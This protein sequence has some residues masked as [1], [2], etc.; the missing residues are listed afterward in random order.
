MEKRL[1][2][3][4]KS[5]EVRQM[6]HTSRLAIGGCDLSQLA[7]EYGTP[8]YIY[9]QLALDGAVDEA[10]VEMKAVG[11]AALSGAAYVANEWAAP[12]G[13]STQSNPSSGCRW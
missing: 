5:T 10:N 6:G 11:A 9:D 2:L 12:D 3:F 13:C 4:P 8:L 7:D 1:Q